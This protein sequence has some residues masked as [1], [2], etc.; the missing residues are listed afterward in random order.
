MKAYAQQLETSSPA[1]LDDREIARLVESYIPLVL[2]QVDRAWLSPRL[3]LTREDLVSA[4][5]YGLLLAAR[6]FD[7]SR[8]VGFGV[9][10]RTHVHGA[11]M[12]E[13][14]TA[15]KAA[16]AGN[17]DV[18]YASDEVEPDSLPDENAGA[19]VDSVETAQVREL[20][21]LNLTERERLLVTLYYYEELTLA[22]IAAVVDE[23]ES[24]VSRA[25][26]GAIVQL[27]TALNDR[28]GDEK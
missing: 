9:F 2:H 14:Q 15:M 12:R 24:T 1:I 7:P 16:G 11:L 20:M 13:I 25:L 3:G 23:S 22:E 10:A 5:C 19:T 27:R 28:K 4:G 18:L 17:E 21:E 26:N 6:K 8:G